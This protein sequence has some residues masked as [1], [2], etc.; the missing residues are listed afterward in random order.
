[1]ADALIQEAKK[2]FATIQSEN[3]DNVARFQESSRFLDADGQW[4]E[5][6]REKRTKAGRPCLSFPRVNQYANKIVNEQRQI[7]RSIKALPVGDTSDKE[8]AEVIQGL[9][10]NIEAQSDAPSVYADTYQPAVE[11]GWGFM[12]VA[13]EFPDEE[14]WSQEL[15]IK[16]IYN[17]LSVSF[18]HHSMEPDGSDADVCFVSEHLSHARY[19]M[20]YGGSDL[21]EKIQEGMVFETIGDP[22]WGTKDDCRVTEF[23]KRIYKAGKLYR[24]QSADGEELDIKSGDARLPVIK[25]KAEPDVEY[26]KSIGWSIMRERATSVPTVKCYKINGIEILKEWDWPGKYIPIVPMYGI[27]RLVEGKRKVMGIVHNAKDAQRMYNYW[28]THATEMIAL[29]PKAPFIGWRG[30]FK[31]PKWLTANT[32]NHPYL[33]AER[34]GPDGQIFDTHPARQVYEPAIQAILQMAQHASENLKAVTGLPDAS[35][36]VRTNETSGRAIRERK[37]EGDTTTFHFQDNARRSIRHIARICIDAIPK[38]YDVPA[39]LRILAEDDTPREV[40][41]NQENSVKEAFDIRTGQ[42]DV[43]IEDGP[44]FSTK[45]KEGSEALVELAAVDPMLMQ[46]SRDIVYKALDVP[47]ATDLADRARRSLPPELIGEDEEGQK[48]PPKAAQE[49]FALR[50]ENEQM[51]MLIQEMEEKAKEIVD[52]RTAKILEIDSKE[53]IEAMKAQ[54]AVLLET[55]KQQ[56]AQQQQQQ[57]MEL[58]GMRTQHQT[59]MQSQQQQFEQLMAELEYLRRPTEDATTQ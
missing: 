59:E 35:M 26:L 5:A 30:Q 18:D 21:A 25:G 33:E 32:A 13:T 50:T 45:R 22:G 37:E 52:Q 14:S 7:K 17:P 28:M 55:M 40:L 16:R 46:T 27:L 44:S 34:V 2:L 58:E 23:W 4:P 3:K 15:R 8:K 42:Y 11:A 53:N 31:D 57:A 51:K 9:F 12:R 48:I 29:A 43:V 38:V 1:M 54:L 47:Y 24:L 6:E 49:L 19:K 36:G 41:V 10:R 39:A 20:Q 56:A